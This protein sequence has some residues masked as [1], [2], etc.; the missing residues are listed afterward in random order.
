MNNLGKKIRE[1]RECKEIPLRKLA[2]IL[3]ID[4]SILSKI[5]RGTRKATKEQVK[6]L[7]EYFEVS[8]K[9]LL[10]D[11]LSDRILYTLS[12]EDVALEA[13]QL[14]EEQVAY[15]ISEKTN[16]LRYIKIIKSIMVDFPEVT[17][18]WIF[19]S[20]S[21]KDDDDSSDIDIA[22][23]VTDSFSYFDLAEIKYKLEK[24][25]KRKIDIGFIDSVKPHVLKNI[26][27]DLK[28]IYEKK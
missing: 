19:G 25:L 22:I 5:E 28:L 4:Q 20:F 18:A 8:E 1:L 9:E 24:K 2:S 7:A 16:H 14:A 12:G 13:L 21:R 27:Q 6:K 11:W 17:K 10:I 3:E 23:D 26:G 15:Q